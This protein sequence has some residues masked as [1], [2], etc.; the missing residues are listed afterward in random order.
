MSKFVEKNMTCV[1]CGHEN[2]VTILTAATTQGAADLDSR[3][4]EKRRSAMPLWVHACDRCKAVFSVFEDTPKVDKS[5][6]DTQKYE[7]C[8]GIAGLPELAKNFVKIALIYEQSGEVKKAGN[9]FL[10]AAWCC[11]DNK[12]YVNAK[13]CREEALRCWNM[14]DATEVNK[15]ELPEL[16]LKIIDTLRRSEHFKEARE[17]AKCVRTNDDNMK[18]VLA[19]EISKSIE[20]DTKCYTLLDAIRK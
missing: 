14:V 15:R 11:D 8:A 19:F 17:F 13:L 5:F 1:M 12:L 16:Q 20:K 3:P 10:N 6:L 9:Y 7:N 2:A 4:P 18:Q